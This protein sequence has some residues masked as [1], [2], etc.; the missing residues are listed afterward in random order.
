MSE[1]WVLWG[2]AYGRHLWRLEVGSLKRCNAAHKRRTANGTAT[3]MIIRKSG[4]PYRFDIDAPMSLVEDRGTFSA[5][6]A[7]TDTPEGRYLAAEGAT[8]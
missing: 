4:R 5:F 3:E 2:Y 1:T 7:G 6:F 8:A